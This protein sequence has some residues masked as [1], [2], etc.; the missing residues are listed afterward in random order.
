MLG[1]RT[2]WEYDAAGRVTLRAL[3]SVRMCEDSD[4]GDYSECG[5]P[6]GID[7]L[8]QRVRWTEAEDGTVTARGDPRLVLTWD[9]AGRLVRHERLG[10]V[11]TYAYRGDTHFAR[12]E[13]RGDALTRTSHD[14][15][16]RP[17]LQ[18][19][20]RGARITRVRS[21][22]YDGYGNL[23][24]MRL[25]LPGR[26]LANDQRWVWTYDARGRPTELTL[27]DHG[28]TVFT[29]GRRYDD[30]G[31]LVART[32]RGEEVRVKRGSDG[33]VRRV[34]HST[35]RCLAHLWPALTR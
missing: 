22:R 31:R 24:A 25:V 32:P 4:F 9:P 23:Q 30:H 16:G 21:W 12:E 2:R 29:E 19:Q 14:A 34:G 1:E 13:R 26:G 11:T 33:S 6:D 17:V 7:D 5:P 8:V 3:D 15:R 10:E 18:A 27:L 20:W 35:Y 28:E